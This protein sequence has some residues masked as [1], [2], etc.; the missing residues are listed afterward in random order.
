MNPKLMNEL[1]FIN[2]IDPK[3]SSLSLD[4]SGTL[5]E[6]KRRSGLRN[7]FSW[8]IHII[9][10]TL[11][12]RNKGLDEVTR[13]ILNETKDSCS[14]P[15]Q[16]K[17][18]LAQAMTKL[19]AIIKENGG[20]EGKKVSALLQT[21]SK[22]DN[23]EAVKDL[24]K[25]SFPQ[26]IPQPVP[27][28]D[29]RLQNFLNNEIEREATG[30]DSQQGLAELLLKIEGSVDL[31]PKQHQHL[32]WTLKSLPNQWVQ[33]HIHQLP[34]S[35]I[36]FLGDKCM[37][38]HDRSSFFKDC[39]I[40]LTTE[41][42]D[43]ARLQALIQSI[44]PY[45]PYVTTSNFPDWTD[46]MTKDRVQWIEKQLDQTHLN[47]FIQNFFSTYLKA[48]PF[49]YTKLQDEI[50]NVAGHFSTEN[51]A[52]IWPILYREEKDHQ[53]LSK[54]ILSSQKEHEILKNLL[55]EE[56]ISEGI[57]SLMF[58]NADLI[59]PAHL[60]KVLSSV[61]HS[62]FPK[63]KLDL[64]D[65]IPPSDIL[66]HFEDIPEAFLVTLDRQRL[67]KIVSESKKIKDLPAATQKKLAEVLEKT[68][69]LS[70]IDSNP[71]L[72][73]YIS[74]TQQASILERHLKTPSFAS[75]EKEFF[76][77]SQKLPLNVWQEASKKL[78]SGLYN[79]EIKELAQR[80][81]ALPLEE[82]FLATIVNEQN[83]L[84]FIK[85]ILPFNVFHFLNPKKLDLI[86]YAALGIE[87][88]K[89]MV[90]QMDPSN[91]NA[92]TCLQIVTQKVFAQQPFNPDY[93]YSLSE[94]QWRSLPLQNYLPHIQLAIAYS[95]DLMHEPLIR[96]TLENLSKEDFY[97]LTDII[98]KNLDPDKVIRLFNGAVD[99]ISQNPNSAAL[100]NL[101][102]KTL[103][104]NPQ[105]FPSL[106]IE[107]LI[108]LSE[109]STIIHL[110]QEILLSLIA[111]LPAKEAR[112]FVLN[113]WQRL[114]NTKEYNKIL[115]LLH[116]PE[117]LKEFLT[118]PFSPS[119]NFSDQTYSLDDLD[120]IFK[121]LEKAPW[122]LQILVDKNIYTA[123]L[124]EWI[125]KNQE[126]YPHC[127]QVL[128]A[129]QTKNWTDDK[130]VA[131]SQELEKLFEYA[132]K[133]DYSEVLKIF[134][135]LPQDTQD[136]LLKNTRE[137]EGEALI[138]DLWRF[139]KAEL[140][141]SL[142]DETAS[143][144]IKQTINMFINEQDNLPISQTVITVVEFINQLNRLPEFE[145]ISRE[146]Y[147]DAFSSNK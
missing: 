92:K 111:L 52:K 54:M 124:Y 26:G 95:L 65:K 28:T 91:E 78:T 85:E 126:H 132:E 3:Q 72:I 9:T 97:R 107:A 113:H 51:Q 109:S 130:G 76:E 129:Y 82:K 4:R 79:K 115:P 62:S 144:N 125:V 106:S 10:L 86:D 12:P 32:T 67:E 57:V 114:V 14:L 105:L 94:P 90:K 66:N 40:Q 104:N 36:R 75:N 64:F 103:S 123:S 13:H 55:V 42:L 110:P 31:T 22:V 122:K 61:F 56:K 100:Y 138:S 89:S 25:V 139:N 136:Y 118:A 45:G 84:Q 58:L 50:L 128:T 146:F 101:L 140:F 34:P 30:A 7:F 46:I 48:N 71:A 127:L 131:L 143:K 29:R 11:V 41:P 47:H 87:E 60:E 135:S 21:L 2:T 147:K 6:E 49:V 20:S 88:W 121:Q 108:A 16:D 18:I 15:D 23:L 74:P 35:L 112:S 37:H 83:N 120:P 119:Y 102:I 24:K 53:F 98:N 117:K 59:K 96:K 142:A 99:S 77:E 116:E 145:G 134:K 68:N 133:D 33:D 8:V 17:L 73:H 137:T 141:L 43:L 5:I 39:F 19:Q 70:L 38:G 63:L 27:S 93:F 69:Q 44:P 81:N 1:T 80:L